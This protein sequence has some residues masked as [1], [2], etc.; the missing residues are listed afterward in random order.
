MGTHWWKGSELGVAAVTLGLVS[1]G[2]NYAVGSDETGGQGGSSTGARSGVG[3]GGD[4]SGGR[5]GAAAGGVAGT[6]A[7]GGSAAT[8]G[9]QGCNLSDEPLPAFAPAAPEVVWDRLSSFFYGAYREPFEPLP[10]ATT[11]AWVVGR[12][13]AILERQWAEDQRA[14]DGLE[15]FMQDWAFEGDA[16]SA[17]LWATAFARPAGNFADLFAT[18]DDRASFLSDRAFLVARPTP[19]RRGN[20]MAQNLACNGVQ[21][22]P[23]ELEA[24]PVTVPPNMTRREALE[25]ETSDDV[26]AGCH[27]MMDPLGFSLE[28]YDELGNYRATENGLPIDTSGGYSFETFSAYFTGIENL[29][30]TLILACDSQNCFG[31]GLLQYALDRARPGGAAS[32]E[33]SESAYVF[34]EFTGHNLALGP[35]LEA[36]AT[37]PAFLRE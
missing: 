19:S 33:P 14:P 15:Q 9:A 2:G 31:R 18:V 34:R 29:S 7:G 3:S 32:F 30:N 24:D 6:G 5:G 8:G 26:C 1:C 37:T 20:W 28:N 21:A 17:R 13:R 27:R 35:L 16:E 4:A 11:K 23:P 12:V 22:P 36:I 25:A 10:E